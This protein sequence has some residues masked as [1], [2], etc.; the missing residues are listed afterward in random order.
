MQTDDETCKCE[1]IV[2]RCMDYRFHAQ[3]PELLAEHFGT[4]R[5]EYD[6]PGG[7]GG[8]KSLIDAR[9]REFVL[10]ALE[11]ALSLHGVRRLIIVDHVDC[12]TYGGSGEFDSPEAERRFHA[13]RLRE[14]AEI[15]SKAQPGLEIVLLYQDWE[16]ISSV[17]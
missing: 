10:E 9:S 8:S 2:V 15:A 11:L 3:L 6:S 1:S 5:F 12:G 13:E 14:A 7:T 4:E 16:G 17:E